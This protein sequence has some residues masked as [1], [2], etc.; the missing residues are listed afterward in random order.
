MSKPASS[1]FAASFD[2]DPELLKAAGIAVRDSM[3]IQP[4]ER[5]LLVTN[6]PR[7]VMTIS[8]ALFDAVLEAGGAPTI[9][10]QGIKAQMD[11]AEDSVIAAFKAKPDVV[12]SI[13]AEKLG[14]DREAIAKPYLHGGA[15]YDHL[16]HYLLRG[17]RSIRAFWSPSV[18]TAM[19]RKTVPIDYA[20]LQDR[21]R[22]IA[23]ILD[24]SVSV[25]VTNPNG[26]DLRIGLRGR[27]AKSDDGDFSRPGTG[28]N[29]PA[30]EV[31]VS[32]ALGAAEGLIVYDGSIADQVGDII[33]REPI[34]CRV[35][36]GFVVDLAGGEEAAAL[37]RTLD[38]AAESARRLGAEGKLPPDKAEA[39]AKNARS[40]GELG[41]G[42]NPRAAVIGNMLED[43]KA[44]K[45]CHFAI[46]S[47]YDEDA[48]AL[49]HLDGL[50]SR[51]TIVAYGPQGEETFIER[52]GELLI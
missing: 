42:L 39:Y 38:A 51:P 35:E 17:E 48:P 18:T 33:I 22:R 40:I 43:E 37:R 27:K 32:P 1:T 12:M 41:I 23:A 5:V 19:F 26:T 9:V 34:R 11:Y 24:A 50:V 46:G 29:L 3:K 10:V 2:L 4:G 36:G 14:K 49:I 44:F 25:R 31:F 45:T 47:N 13:S 20:L 28:G 6:P 7:E 30:G 52:D 21:C 16:F 8:A 15:S